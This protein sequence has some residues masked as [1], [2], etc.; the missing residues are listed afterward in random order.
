MLVSM[1]GIYGYILKKD[2]IKISAFRILI[3]CASTLF[4]QVPVYLNLVS[5]LSRH[6]CK[7]SF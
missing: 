7:N 2:N 5:F 3:I 4:L 1:G 6:A